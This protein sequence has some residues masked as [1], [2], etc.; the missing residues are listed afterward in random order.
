MEEK[1]NGDSLNILKNG[2]EWN[3]LDGGNMLVA[4]FPQKYGLEPVESIKNS[5]SPHLVG[6]YRVRTSHR[7]AV[8]INDKN[9]NKLENI[10]NNIF[11]D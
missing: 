3:I 7:Y 10:L 6:Y 11:G 1:I 9:S 4:T 2:N 8:V 5:Y